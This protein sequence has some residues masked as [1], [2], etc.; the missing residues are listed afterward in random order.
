M[1]EFTEAEIVEGLKEIRQLAQGEDNPVRG[2]D[3]YM[4]RYSKS[5]ST[6]GQLRLR[7]L[8]LDRLMSEVTDAL[9][10]PRTSRPLAGGTLQRRQYSGRDLAAGAAAEDRADS[11]A[12]EFR[13]AREE[14]QGAA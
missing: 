2:L 11:L 1:A 13:K 5:L 6:Q 12:E 10:R 14:N 4:E 3:K 8:F 9:S 7:E